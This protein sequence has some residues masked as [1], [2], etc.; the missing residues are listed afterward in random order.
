MFEDKATFT[1]LSEIAEQAKKRAEVARYVTDY[2]QR[3]N[4]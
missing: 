2:F 1:E 3:F 4:H